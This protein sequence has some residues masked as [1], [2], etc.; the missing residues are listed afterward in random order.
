MMSG[1][2]IQ[3]TM[4]GLNVRQSVNYTIIIMLSPQSYNVNKVE[5]SATSSSSALKKTR[6]NYYCYKCKE[7][8]NRRK[9]VD[10]SSKQQVY[11]I[12]LLGNE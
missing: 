9:L 10:A 11:A 7:D 12:E 6:K 2:N 1:L 8:A 5:S 4:S 3:K